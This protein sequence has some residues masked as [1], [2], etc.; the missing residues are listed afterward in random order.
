MQSRR[1]RGRR[2]VPPAQLDQ[3][4]VRRAA[5]LA[6]ML[7][8]QPAAAT[9]LV[10][11]ACSRR[12]GT[13]RRA[14]E[15]NPYAAELGQGLSPLMVEVVRGYLTRR[16]GRNR[17]RPPDGLTARQ[18]AL[19]E[20]LERRPRRER[21]VLVLRLVEHVTLAEVVAVLDGGVRGV[22]V[23]SGYSDDEVAEVLERLAERV[24][25][26]AQL[27]REVPARAAAVRRARRRRSVLAALGVSLL[28]AAVAVPFLVLPR[29]P[30]TPRPLGAWHTYQRTV[31]PAGWTLTYRA[32]G[33][34][35]EAV[36][37][38]HGDADHSDQSCYV[39]VNAVGVDTRAGQ[40]P[41]S[42]ASDPVRVHWRPGSFVH[43]DGTSTTGLRWQY[44]RDA[45]AEV[46]CEESDDRRLLKQI[47]TSWVRLEQHPLLVPLRVAQLPGGYRV[48]TVVLK[49]DERVEPEEG[50]G[51]VR[52]G[53]DRPGVPRS[54]TLSVD[55]AVRPENVDGARRPGDTLRG[56]PVLTAQDGSRACVQPDPAGPWTCVTA[57]SSG[58]SP[59]TGRAAVRAL[60]LG[61]LG[62]VT[63]ADRLG[64]RSTWFDADSAFAG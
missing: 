27:L 22:P 21:V 38:V 60:V 23:L 17:P 8:G 50:P 64:D 63:L 47:A 53:I 11:R 10:G 36:S 24:P 16:A 31:L 3:A 52:V 35:Y 62:R 33:P 25:A 13:D 34:D 9:E 4:D 46:A 39:V 18:R 15:G 5:R 48:S 6:V 12:A 30:G 55:F 19:L 7:T 37:F 61:T 41:P 58:G 54:W 57:Y 51:P 14:D 59:P 49:E 2:P 56:R 32:V 42:S 26:T 43:Y 40:E 1:P 28:A 20:E 44:A 45:W 29:L